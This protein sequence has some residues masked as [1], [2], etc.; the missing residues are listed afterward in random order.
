MYMGEEYYR[1]YLKGDDGGFVELVREYKDGLVFYLKSI[2]H[3]D[4]LAEELMEETFFKLATRRPRYTGKASF[5]TW[6]YTIAR[7]VALD[8]LRKQKHIADT[9]LEELP[10]SIQSEDCVETSFLKKE[11]EIQLYGALL[12]LNPAYRQVLH[13]TYFQGFTNAETAVIMKKTKR[14]V[15]NLLTRARKSLREQLEKEGF[16]YEEL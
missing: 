2:V 14:Q 3:S 7:N 6:L 16:S 15:E 9:S 13:L 8:E 5:K 11:R 4:G 1:Q 10:K 12:A